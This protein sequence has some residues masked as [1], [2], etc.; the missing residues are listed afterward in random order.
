M[1]TKADIDLET[2]L[3]GPSPA[4]KEKINRTSIAARMAGL[5]LQNLGVMNS[6][7]DD[8]KSGEVIAFKG[9]VNENGRF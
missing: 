9:D 8:L 1:R 2:E 6:E 5:E 7:D 4:K 3:I